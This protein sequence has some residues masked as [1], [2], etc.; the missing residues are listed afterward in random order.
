MTIHSRLPCI[1]LGTIQLQTTLLFALWP[2]IIRMRR[3][4]GSDQGRSPMTRTRTPP[5]KPHT[6]LNEVGRGK[7]SLPS[8]N[9]HTVFSQGDAADAVFYIQAGKVKLTV[10]S[11]QGK[12]AVVAI[13]E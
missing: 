12:E 7:T 9:K 1:A 3:S 10:V 13:L 6:F 8:P 2:A 5:F 4:L 11:Q